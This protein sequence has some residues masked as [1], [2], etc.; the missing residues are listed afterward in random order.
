MA[1]RRATLIGST[2]H[3]VEDRRFLENK[4]EIVA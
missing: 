2:G 1:T 3:P 4:R